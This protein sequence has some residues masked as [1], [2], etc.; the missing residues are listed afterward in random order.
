MC[1]IAS[2]GPFRKFD[3]KMNNTMQ[4]A[5]QKKWM[6]LNG[7]MPIYLMGK[8]LWFDDRRI[9][10]HLYILCWLEPFLCHLVMYKIFSNDEMCVGLDI[11]WLLGMK[12]GAIGYLKLLMWKVFSYLCCVIIYGPSIFIWKFFDN[13]NLDIFQ[14]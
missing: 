3:R 2:K 9:I 8:N 5:W 10:M 6:V 14:Q 12:F 7:A 1:H 13:V 11:L 4:C